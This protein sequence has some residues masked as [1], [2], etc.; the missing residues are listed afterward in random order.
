MTTDN[1]VNH[2]GL[3][4]LSRNSDDV[5]QYYDNW[6]ANYDNT[7][8]EWQ[9]DAPEQ[10]AAMLKADLPLESIILDAGCGT[11]LSGRALCAIGFKMIDGIDV[12]ARSL[13]IAEGSNIYRS[14]QQVDMQALPLPLATDQYDGLAC[15]GVLTY[16]PDSVGTVREF[17]RIVKSGGRVVLTQRSDLF[18]ERDFEGVLNT[19][20]DEGVIT[21][22]RV[23]E[24]HPYLPNHKEFANQILV[25]YISYRV[26]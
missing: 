18:A 12:S 2:D 15:V 14:L 19:L 6:A 1:T 10:V 25:H 11:G 26:V 24:A 13:E 17:S 16:L 9:Y 3:S 22:V 7:L 5:A 8:A 23:S 21:Q 4:T 20:A